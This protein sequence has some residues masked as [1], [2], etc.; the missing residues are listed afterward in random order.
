[1]ILAASQAAAM[2][3]AVLTTS[4]L[5][6]RPVRVTVLVVLASEGKSAID[7]KLKALAQEVSKREPKLTSFTLAQSRSLAIPHEKTHEFTLIDKLTM[8]VKVVQPRNPLGRVKLTIRPPGLGEITY[9]CVC[10]KYLPIVTPEVTQSG[11]RLILAIM[12]TP[13]LGP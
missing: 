11:H 1:M 8:P 9:E 7:P 5:E 10:G 12:A 4:K 3:L 2:A 6:Q 13:C